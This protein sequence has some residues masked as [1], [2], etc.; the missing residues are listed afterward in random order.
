MFERFYNWPA[1]QP[2]ENNHFKLQYLLLK[3]DR[4]DS[5]YL[6]RILGELKNNAS[7]DLRAVFVP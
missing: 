1:T 6:G 4:N 2:Q 3:A 7:N 5:T